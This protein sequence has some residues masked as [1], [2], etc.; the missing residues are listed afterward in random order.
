[1]LITDTTD[2]K[3]NA[4]AAAQQHSTDHE[5]QLFIYLH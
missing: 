3:Q 5:G 4:A 2:S 1:M